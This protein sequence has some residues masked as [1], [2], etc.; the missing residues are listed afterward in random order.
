MEATWLVDFGAPS[1]VVELFEFTGR[2]SL[3]IHQV[4]DQH[5]NF[6]ILQFN[7]YQTE[8][9]MLRRQAFPQALFDGTLVGFEDNHGLCL[10]T[11]G[12]LFVK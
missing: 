7:A 3:L 9:E 2:E 11:L 4:G 6:A 1:K 10:A 8:S 12:K 5:F